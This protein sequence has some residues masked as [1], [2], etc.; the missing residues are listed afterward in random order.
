[1]ATTSPNINENRQILDRMAAAENAQQFLTL[2]GEY[3]RWCDQNPPH[4][5]PPQANW[6][7]AAEGLVKL[8]STI[9]NFGQ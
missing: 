8:A 2:A 1:M 3:C 9:R 6:R 4:G 5:N 7:D